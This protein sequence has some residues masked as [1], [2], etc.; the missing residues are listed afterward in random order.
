MESSTTESHNEES[1]E[2]LR[3]IPNCVCKTPCSCSLSKVTAKYREAEYVMCF[4]KGLNEIYNTIKTQV[5]L[6]EPLPDINC[7]FSLVIQQER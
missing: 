7:V 2:F 3:P 5:L 4:L 6:M 1:S